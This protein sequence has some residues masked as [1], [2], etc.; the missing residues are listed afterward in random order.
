V[1]EGADV[2]GRTLG[3]LK[4]RQD[5]GVMV[6]AIR[7]PDGNMLFNPPSDTPIAAGDFLI[8]MGEQSHLRA[9]DRLLAGR[10]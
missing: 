7:K 2:V 8:A 1:D 5:T 3:D 6:L 10:K 4:L 9:F